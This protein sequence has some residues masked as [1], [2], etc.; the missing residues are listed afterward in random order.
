MAFVDEITLKMRAGDGGDGVVRWR[1]EKGKD[2][3]GAAG[4]NG[5]KGGDVYARAVSD[6][7]LLA[8]YRSV[9][10]FR[11][12]NGKP[13]MKSSMHGKNGTDLFVEFPVGSVLTNLE[14]GKTFSLEKTGD[15]VRLLIGGR[16]GLGNE[17]FKASTNV[18]PR[19]STKGR[20]GEEASFE[21]ELRLI[22]DI[23]L[24]GLPNAGKSSLL[25]ALTNTKVKVGSYAF[26]TLEPNL[27]NMYGLILADIP[28]LIKGASHGRGLGHAFLRHITRTKILAHCISL[29][30]PHITEAYKTIRDE[31]AEYG[32][33]LATKREI[34]VLTKADIV[35]P[36]VAEQKKKEV[37]SLGLSADVMTV[38]V[39]DADSIKALRDKLSQ[40]ASKGES[41][42]D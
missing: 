33:E 34:I 21:I 8:Q 37:I 1:H 38:S 4:G 23:G 12:D 20:P 10:E 17:H 24:I 18:R 6:I 25:N 9:K 39:N 26:T 35:G 19:E 36:E 3:A 22:A 28:G 29:E 32:R 7:G 27:G 2:K 16:G 11:A 13:G 5:G 30:E 40:V 14:T 31:L 15:T 42:S 41:K